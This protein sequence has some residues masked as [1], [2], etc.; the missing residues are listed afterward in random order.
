MP[1]TNTTTE[2]SRPGRLGAI[3]ATVG[4][5]LSGGDADPSYLEATVRHGA[6]VVARVSLS[7]QPGSFTLDVHPADPGST[8]LVGHWP[9]VPAHPTDTTAEEAAALDGCEALFRALMVERGVLKAREAPTTT[10]L[11]DLARDIAGL[12][13]RSPTSRRLSGRAAQAV[14]SADGSAK[15]RKAALDLVETCAAFHMDAAAC[16]AEPELGTATRR[17]RLA[18]AESLGRLRRQWETGSHVGWLLPP[19]TDEEAVDTPSP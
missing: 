18:T 12:P 11:M 15:A 19:A 3:L 1:R 14:A 6:V 16:A 9:G 10:M 5:S 17:A 13:D 8:A 7:S 4:L 2:R